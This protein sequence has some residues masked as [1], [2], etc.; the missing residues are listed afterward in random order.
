VDTIV[1]SLFVNPSLPTVQQTFFVSP[2]LPFEALL[3]SD[4]LSTTGII[5]DCKN[6]RLMLPGGKSLSLK[7]SRSSVLNTI[8]P[9]QTADGDIPPHTV[10]TGNAAPVAA[11]TYRIPYAEREIVSTHVKKYLAKGWIE[12]ATS[13]WAS[14]TLIVRRNGK[15][16]LCVDFRALNAITVLDRFPAPHQTRHQLTVGEEV[17]L[18]DSTTPVG[19]KSKHRRHWTGPFVVSKITGPLSYVVTA[20][21]GAIAYRAHREHLKRVYVRPAEL[22]QAAADTSA[23]PQ[24]ASTATLAKQARQRNQLAST[25]GV[26]SEASSPGISV[27]KPQHANNE[28]KHQRR[29]Q[30]AEDADT[31]GSKTPSDA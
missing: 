19:L 28:T 11:R 12:R 17:M 8:V 27:A 1:T 23:W 30:R 31:S 4:A 29:K 6:Q 18:L 22:E 9:G 13:E 2:T 24:Q 5:V 20:N 15:G 16:R 7:R 21:N 26:S 25:P 10:N 14:P 3:G